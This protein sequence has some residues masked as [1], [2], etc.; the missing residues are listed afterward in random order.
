MRF[1]D[2]SCIIPLIVQEPTSSLLASAFTEDH[3]IVVWWGAEVECVHGLSKKFRSKHPRTDLEDAL[4]RLADLMEGWIEIQPTDEVRVRA[5]RLLFAR[6][7]KSADAMQL[8]A[9][10]LWC[11]DAPEEVGFICQDRQLRIAARQE[12]FAVSP[13]SE[14]LGVPF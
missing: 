6:E 1:W 5:E 13:T 4:R 3:D 2:T 12:G 11:D 8:G 7:L 10:L 14:Q 9:A